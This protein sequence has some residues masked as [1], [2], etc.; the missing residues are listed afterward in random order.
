MTSK[1]TNG[2]GDDAM[3]TTIAPGVA[4]AIRDFRPTPG[5][6]PPYDTGL[7]R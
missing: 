4:A 2:P 3:T 7:G 6:K 5:G 1:M